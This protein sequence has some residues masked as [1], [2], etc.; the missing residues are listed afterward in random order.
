MIDEL[1]T[2]ASDVVARAKRMGATAAD[3]LAM[4][5]RST[6]VSIN[7]G[8][9]EKLEQSESND[10]GLRVFVGNSSALISSSVF[11]SASLD[12]LVERAIDMAK[13]APP[14]PFAGIADA[15]L[16]ATDVPDLDLLSPDEI[17][18]AQ[19]QRMAEDV[20]AVAL[21]V[22][23]VSKSSGADASSSHGGFG[24]VTSNGFS[25]G[26]ARNGVG[27]S[28]SVIAGE[29]TAMERDYDGHGATYLSD[30]EGTE[31]I[32]RT[33]GERAVKR[34]N[35]RK[36]PSQSVPIIYDRRVATSL[37]SHC[38]SAIN[39]AAIARGTS[40]LKDDRG[41]QIFRE[42]INV[43]E[44]PH[45]L[46]GGSSRPF[47]GEG[48]PT[49]RRSIIENGILTNWI[50]DLRSARKLELAPTGQGSRGGPSTSNIYMEAGVDTPE[51][52]IKALN[53]GLL[54]TEFIGSTINPVTGDYSRGASGYW[55]ENGEIAFPVSEITIGGNL[56]D[57]FKSMTPA[58]DLIFR[59][60]FSAPSC[61]VEG[62]TIA[63]K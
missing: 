12:R 40:F 7:H 1:L 31:K 23:G 9:V 10:I 24:L 52:M 63:G 50:L 60:S 14:D 17:T 27:L 5:S 36:V 37:V 25:K 2:I 11:D 15:S 53:K 55:I 46:R 58:N 45:R 48:L 34:L 35:P 21:S 44:D 49:Q 62:M 19:L 29:G 32:G 57:M 4:E 47:D 39:G 13:L 16:L 59:G 38:L 18:A 56:R 30:L 28:V 42:Q 3:A 43:I 26:Y 8:K 6:E 33:A 41:K 61:L 22:P 54:V 20:E 51:A